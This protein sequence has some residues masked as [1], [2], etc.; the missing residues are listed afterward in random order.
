MN[1]KAYPDFG[2]IISKI[3]GNNNSCA[4]VTVTKSSDLSIPP[5]ISTKVVSKG[6]SVGDAN[7]NSTATNLIERVLEV[8]Y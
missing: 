2:F 7:C 5:I 3:G 4:I 1:P 6:Y 8:N